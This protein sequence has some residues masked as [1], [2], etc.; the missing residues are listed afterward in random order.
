[1]TIS[2]HCS[3]VGEVFFNR[4]PHGSLPA[5]FVLRG[6]SQLHFEWNIHMYIQ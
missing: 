6:E 2:W 5:D 1:M 3:I 4:L